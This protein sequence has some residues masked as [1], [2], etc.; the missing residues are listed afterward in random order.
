VSA[1]KRNAV[2]NV[3]PINP[4]YLLFI[5]CKVCQV[6]CT[7]PFLGNF[8]FG[9]IIPYPPVYLNQQLSIKDRNNSS[10][11]ITGELARSSLAGRQWDKPPD[12]TTIARFS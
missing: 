9:R 2:L 11:S 3:F 7:W 6:R 12:T 1:V 4:I 5:G 8:L 10:D